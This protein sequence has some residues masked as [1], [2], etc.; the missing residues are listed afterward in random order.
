MN[1]KWNTKSNRIELMQAKKKGRSVEKSLIF[2]L[3]FIHKLL[4]LS[5]N[6]RD[7]IPKQTRDHCSGSTNTLQFEGRWYFSF[8]TVALVS[9][10]PL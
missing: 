3:Q 6:G 7:V 9:I 10:T 2:G 4:C 1:W 5:I 8:S